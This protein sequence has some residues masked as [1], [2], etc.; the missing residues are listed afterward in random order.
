MVDEKDP[1]LARTPPTVPIFFERSEG[2][3]ILDYIFR[4]PDGVEQKRTININHQSPYMLK[5]EHI[6]SYYLQKLRDPMCT[7]EVDPGVC[8]VSF[9]FA[10]SSF[11]QLFYHLSYL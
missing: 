6:G 3:W 10:V 5:L 1:L 7:G 2:P 9:K 11:I 8:Q 4:A